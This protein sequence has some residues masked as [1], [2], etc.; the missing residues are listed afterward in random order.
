MPEHV[1]LDEE[2]KIIF[3]RS[4]GQVS[5]ESLHDAIVDIEQLANDSGVH[6]IFVDTTDQ[7]TMPATLDVFEFMS[8]LPQQLSYAL[9][10]TQDQVTLDSIEF[11]ETVALNRFRNIKLF[12]DRE[13]AM[14][15]L[16]KDVL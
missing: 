13:D 7:E 1:E 16:E 10:T 15:W 12:H 3:V 11:A 14:R 2:R 6:R 5:A 9:L 4:H 8:S